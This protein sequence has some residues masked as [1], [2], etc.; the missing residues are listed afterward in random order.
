LASVACWANRK[1]SS[2]TPSLAA[3]DSAVEEDPQKLLR[4]D[5]QANREE[6]LASLIGPAHGEFPRGW[7][8]CAPNTPPRRS[9]VR[10][11]AATYEAGEWQPRQVAL[12]SGRCGWSTPP[13][14]GRCAQS[15]SSLQTAL[16]AEGATKH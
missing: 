2:A 12:W 14:R 15:L 11:R 1:F 13:R 8:I 6:S 9:Q 3:A 10:G 5:D 16:P 7:C 4:R